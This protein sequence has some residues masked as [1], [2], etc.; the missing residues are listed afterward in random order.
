MVNLAA[1]W[2]VLGAA[3][4]VSAEASEASEAALAPMANSAA[5]EV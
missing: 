3:W 5:A 4:V 1:A 2:A